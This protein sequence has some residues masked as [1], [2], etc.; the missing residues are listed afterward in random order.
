MVNIAVIGAGISGLVLARKLQ[1]FA[2]ITIFEKSRG[3]GGRI[4]TRYVGPYHFDHGAQFFIAKTAAFRAFL[5]PLIEAGV[6]QQWH[7][8]F[9]EF[10]GSHLL[11]Q[12]QWGEQKPHYIGVPG[13]N[14]IGKYLA[15]GLNVQKHTCVERC[16]H[17]GRWQLFDEHDGHLGSFDWVVVTTPA[18]QAIPLI[19][20]DLVLSWQ[21]ADVHMLGCFS[22]M[23]GFSSPIELPFDAALVRDAD[24]SW[25]SV[26]SSKPGRAGDF[27]M[28]V[29]STNTWADAHIN[30]DKHEVQAYL[31]EQTRMVTGIHVAQAKHADV[32]TW[33][34]AN[35]GRQKRSLAFDPDRQIAACGDWAIQG[36]VEAAFTSASTIAENMIR[37]LSN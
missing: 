19:P 10:S 32:Q 8:R 5:E 15:T 31:C 34:Y 16:T 18:A 2:D 11:R 3:V 28:L 26:N 6:L 23:L 24:I 36:R 12:V 33:R 22:L 29:H 9:A 35:I 1:P 7:A 13:N 14:A 30:D 17:D 4:A 37:C 27:T 20:A 25:I 21:L